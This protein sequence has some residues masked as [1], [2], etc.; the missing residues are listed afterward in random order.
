MGVL[1]AIQYTNSTP[2]TVTTNFYAF[3]DGNVRTLIDSI[4]SGAT[5][6]IK[7]RSISGVDGNFIIRG[8][9][10]GEPVVATV[11]YKGT[12]SAANA[13]WKTDR[14]AFGKYN[15]AIGDA[16]RFDY[17]RCTLQNGSGQRLTEE[18]ASGASGNI[19]FDVRYVFQIEEQ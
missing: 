5:Y 3:S 18:M 14:D 15:C 13:A 9:Y 12:L 11:R 10:R 2:A 7:R 17:T 16:V 1:L 6:D 4:G 8:G 19:W